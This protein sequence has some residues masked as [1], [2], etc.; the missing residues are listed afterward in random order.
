M[1]RLR[2]TVDNNAESFCWAGRKTMGL[3]SK[4][5]LSFWVTRWRIW[6]CIFIMSEFECFSLACVEAWSGG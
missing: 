5:F 6:K 1:V 3:D 4:D 2:N